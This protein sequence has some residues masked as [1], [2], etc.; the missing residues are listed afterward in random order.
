VQD[1]AKWSGLTTT[2]AR[3]GLEAVKAQLQH[4]EVGG[5]SYWF[6]MSRASAK[7]V[8][9]S[10]YLLSIYDEYISGYKDRTAIVDQSAVGRMRGLGR[11]M[12]I[13]MRATGTAYA[14]PVHCAE[15]YQSSYAT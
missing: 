3:D 5:Q 9:P 12:A 7:A 13:S 6:P 2:D 8:S 11:V 10:A 15:L 14:K 4:D 1:F